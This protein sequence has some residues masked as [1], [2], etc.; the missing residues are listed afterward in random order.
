MVKNF[1]GLPQAA[2]KCV[3]A[4]AAEPAQHSQ[5][6]RAPKAAF[7]PDLAYDVIVDQTVF[8]KASLKEVLKTL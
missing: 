2:G 6:N 8:V 1:G 7:P 3:G 5:Q 4:T